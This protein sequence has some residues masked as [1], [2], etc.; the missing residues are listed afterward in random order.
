MTS[1][2]SKAT[3]KPKTSQNRKTN[4]KI[5]F[6]TIRHFWISRGTCVWYIWMSHMSHFRMG[7]VSHAWMSRL[8]H[9]WISHMSHIRMSHV[10]HVTHVISWHPI[11]SH[12][13]HTLYSVI[14]HTYA[15][16]IPLMWYATW[17]AR[18]HMWHEGQEITCVPYLNTLAEVI[19]YT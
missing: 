8:S 10:T 12:M 11:F 1:R 17:G 3:W 9:V 6:L 14:C 5:Y 15:W 7:H 19:K 16:V 2:W 4:Q 13:S 18:N